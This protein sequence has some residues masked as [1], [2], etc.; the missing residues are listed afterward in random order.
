MNPNELYQ[1]YLNAYGSPQSMDSGIASVAPIASF[2]DS[3][4]GIATLRPTTG[5]GRMPTFFGMTP[6]QY[7]TSY[8]NNP[9]NILGTLASYTLGPVP[10]F[11]TTQAAFA[12]QRKGIIPQNFTD[13]FGNIFNRPVGTTFGDGIDDGIA[14]VPGMN[15]GSMMDDPSLDEGDSGGSDGPGSGADEGGSGADS[16]SGTHSDPGD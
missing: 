5:T 10:G 3:G 11:L 8:V 12:G 4:Q 1:Y 6:G 15:F 9:A 13:M 7:A 14:N 2:Q 16:G